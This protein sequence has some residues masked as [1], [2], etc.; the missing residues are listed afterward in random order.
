MSNVTIPQR[1][2]GQTIDTSWCNIVRNALDGDVTPRNTSGVVTDQIGNLGDTTRRWQDGHT[3]NL[4]LVNSGSKAVILKSAAS[5]TG[6]YSLTMPTTLPVGNRALIVSSLGV[7]TFGQVPTAGI[8]DGAVTPAKLQTRTS[9]GATAGIGEIAVSGTLSV[10][11]VNSGTYADVTGASVTLTTS[12]RPIRIGFTTV[13]GGSAGNEAN[14][15]IPGTQVVSLNF[16]ANGVS[17]GGAALKSNV[18][19]TGISTLYVAAAGTYTIKL[20]ACATGASTGLINS[21]LIAYEI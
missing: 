4:V 15:L 7:L 6:S 8:L 5:L 3:T 14:I 1:N 20:Q 2:D 9:P 19:S 11:I 17:L 13:S 21:K 18:P 12:G 10:G 16:V